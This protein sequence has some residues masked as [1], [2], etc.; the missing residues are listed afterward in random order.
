MPTRD[1]VARQVAERFGL[2]NPDLWIAGHNRWET[3][4]WDA[5]IDSELR[6]EADQVRI[7]ELREALHDLRDEYTLTG[8][9]LDGCR[10]PMCV[11]RKRA[12]ANADSDKPVGAESQ[13][14]NFLQHTG[15]GVCFAHGP[16]KNADKSFV[17]PEWPACITDPQKPEYIAMGKT[18]VGAESG[19]QPDLLARRIAAEQAEDERLWCIPQTAMEAHLQQELRRLTEAVEGK[20]AHQCA[21]DAIFGRQKVSKKRLDFD[22]WFVGFITGTSLLLLCLWLS[23]SLKP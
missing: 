13:R 22:S 1:E 5:L 19:A 12:V 16:Y 14:V 10:H 4:L 7:Q 2:S 20:S 3:K 23:G 11:A 15:E 18:Q 8:A 6:H 9:C 21:M 17:C